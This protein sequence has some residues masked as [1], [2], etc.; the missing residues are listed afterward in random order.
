VD[1]K[2]RQI[3]ALYRPVKPQLDSL[4]VAAGVIGDSTH[5]QIKRLLNPEQQVKFDRIRSESRKDL[6]RRRGK[7]TIIPRGIR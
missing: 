6:A 4:A 5:A 1:Q 7:D 2:H 3:V